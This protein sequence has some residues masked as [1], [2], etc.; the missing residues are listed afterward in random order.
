[1]DCLGYY[2]N[3]LC[4]ID[5]KTTGRQK[6]DGEFDRYYLQC[7]AYTAMVYE[8]RG[9]IVP[10]LLIIMQNLDAGETQVFKAKS[11]N[12]LPKMVEICRDFHLNQK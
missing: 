2:D 5:F 8:H 3:E 6:Y 7:A 1:M 9:L 4:L 10:N 11:K 12:F